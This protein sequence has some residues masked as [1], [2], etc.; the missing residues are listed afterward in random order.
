MTK[1]ER[2]EELVK[3]RKAHI[4]SDG[5]Q[6]PSTIQDG[7][8][9]GHSHIDAWSQWHGN[10]DAR[11]LVIGQ[12]WGDV[13]YF[14]RNNGQLGDNNPTNKNLLKLFLEIG[15]DIGLP[16]QPKPQPIFFTNA[17]LGL[18]GKEGEKTLSGPVKSSW[19]KES[20]QHFTKEL[21]DIIQPKFIITL[22][23]KPLYAL[24]LIYP[25]IP[26][27]KL[28]VLIHKNPIQLKNGTQ[29]F[30]FYHCGSLGLVNRKLD[31]QLEDWKNAKR[32][33]NPRH[34][35]SI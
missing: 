25:E 13:D 28:S 20:T 15:I 3:K 27:E 24:Q 17:I 12:D 35:L 8:F 11:I 23:V 31:D 33:I 14:K 10:I 34:P 16:N 29:L 26:K 4:F 1:Q 18:K 21:I 19:I 30:A 2:Y 6:N 32:S 5:L 7:E 22:G 9:D